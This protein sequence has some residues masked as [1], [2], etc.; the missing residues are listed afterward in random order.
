MKVTI[1]K[2][3]SYSNM[4][5]GKEDSRFPQLTLP[6]LTGLDFAVKLS[7]HRP[8]EPLCLIQFWTMN[9]ASIDRDLGTAS[10]STIFRQIFRFVLIK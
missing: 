10:S 9:G 3:V 2:L 6:G 1:A 4:K 5:I 8:D 7:N